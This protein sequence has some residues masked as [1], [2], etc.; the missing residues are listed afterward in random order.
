LDLLPAGNHSF[1]GAR[2]LSKHFKTQKYAT[3][4]PAAVQ[5][6]IDK[7]MAEGRFQQALELA[8]QLFIHEPTAEHQALLKKAYLSRAKELHDRGAD[9]DAAT[10]L[11]AAVRVDADNAAWVQQLAVELARCGAFQSSFT[12]LRLP[13]SAVAQGIQM[14]AVDAAITKQAAGKSTLPAELHADFD[15]VMLGF[16]HLERGEDEALRATLQQVGLQSPFAEWKL[17]LRGFSAYYQNDD[18]RALENWQRLSPDRTPARLAA[19]F[20]CHIDRAYLT[21][22]PPATQAALQRMFDQLQGSLT[23]Q[24]LRSIRG[25]LASPESLGPALRRLEAV[26]PTLRAEAPQVV[27]RLANCFYWALLDTGPEDVP[28]YRRVFGNPPH[29]PSFH[30]LQAIASEK[31][32]ALEAAHRAWQDYEKEVAERPEIWPAGQTQQVRALIWLHMGQNA[33]QVPS[34]KKLRKLPRPLRDTLPNMRPLSPAAS[35]CFERSL[36]L[37]PDQLEALE[38]L[39]RY[40]LDSDQPA[41]AKKAGKR[42]LK[43][44]PDHVPTLEAYGGLCLKRK[45]YPDGLTALLHA[46]N[47]NPLDRK[48][49]EKVGVARLLIARSAVE[50]IDI[51]AAR[52]EYRA[53][54]GLLPVEDAASILCRWAASEFKAG[55]VARAEELLQQASTHDTPVMAAYCMVTE[56][57]RLK[58]S[59]P[60]KTRFETAFIDG[61]QGTPTAKDVTA[62]VR[63]HAAVFGQKP[64]YAGAKT[65]QTRILKYVDQANKVSFSNTQLEA[66]CRALLELQSRKRLGVFS[67]R[68]QEEY[69]A[70]PV[71]PYL[72]AMSLLAGKEF[73]RC[74]WKA[75]DLLKKA[76]RLVAAQPLEAHNLELNEQIRK[77]LILLDAMNPFGGMMNVFGGP[78]DHFEDDDCDNG[79]FDEW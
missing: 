7:A 79:D 46:L 74:A 17:L 47:S 34:E 49:R 65:H 48:L 61:F 41:Q 33:A 43:V 66:L 18:E 58:L 31:Y 62:L 56:A 28:R 77:Q 57:I 50:R 11:E 51:E 64:L 54:L 15:R 70:D 27:P 71:F 20:R 37:M 52:P 60:L 72:E 73:D 35:T 55:D 23:L 76:E 24:Q 1:A 29:D 10:V 69:P 39:F 13:D 78:L 16:Q 44:H 3:S 45:A 8:K 22:Q 2:A 19:P 5:H 9:R 6:R 21:N 30:K 67:K 12:V 42:L 68:G 14:L 63:Y 59:R 40:Y 75:E 25:M 32:G 38:A 53:A 36:E 4:S 26:L